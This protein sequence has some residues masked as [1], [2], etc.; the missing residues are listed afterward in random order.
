MHALSSQRSDDLDRVAER[1]AR[2]FLPNAS[3]LRLTR[4]GQGLINDTRLLEAQ[5]QRF[6]LQRING[7][8]F[9]DP[10][11]IAGNLLRVQEWLRHQADGSVRLPRLLCAENGAATLRDHDGQAWRLIEF[12]ENSRT[13]RPL[14]HPA[15]AAEVG[16]IL[17]R[18]HRALAGLDPSQLSLTLPELHDTPRY[19]DKLS[20]A[21]AASQAASLPDAER[22]QRTVVSTAAAA[23]SDVPS[24]RRPD[25]TVMAA[26]EQVEYRVELIPVLQQAAAGGILSP[27]V[28]HGDPKLD[29]VLF[30]SDADRALCLIDLDTIQPGLWHQDLADCVRS[31]CNHLG[32]TTDDSPAVSLDL[33][34][35]EALIGGYAE[36]AAPLFDDDAIAL[37]Y[38]AIRLIPIELAMRFL[39]DYLEGDR[40]F[41]VS[42][43]RQNLDKAVIQLA[44]AGDIEDK[45]GRIER[46]I[47]TCFRRAQHQL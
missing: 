41:R 13:L 37:V 42:N 9:K 17:G 46:M 21:L 16:R 1:M 14:E 23:T 31:C 2:Q 12:V 22:P 27:R 35:C 20:A 33:A 32:R 15:Q 40:Y 43:P 47:N 18:F 10:E 6:V 4:L 7:A 19:W 44:L 26:I 36:V 29:N 8:V 45:R 5:S 25:S 11:A 34:F 24:R 3:E 39:T 38:P 30:A 28:T